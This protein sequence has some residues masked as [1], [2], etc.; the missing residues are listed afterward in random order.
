MPLVP[1][2]LLCHSERPNTPLSE[3]P[4]SGSELVALNGR[5]WSFVAA[6]LAGS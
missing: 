2:G 4:V 3:R 6:D 1:S 5:V